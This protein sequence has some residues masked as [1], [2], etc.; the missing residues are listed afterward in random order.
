M[1]VK[2]KI[3]KR[4]AI[5]Y[6]HLHKDTNRTSYQ[7]RSKVSGGGIWNGQP[8]EYTM[9]VSISYTAV[10]EMDTHIV[11]SYGCPFHIPPPDTLLR[12]W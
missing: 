9:C 7:K 3:Y 10:Y 11:Y 12:F 8:Y 6:S 4:S 1:I 5:H 2:Q